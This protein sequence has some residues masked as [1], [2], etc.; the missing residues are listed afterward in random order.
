MTR[1]QCLMTTLSSPSASSILTQSFLSKSSSFLPW[2]LSL[3]AW[4]APGMTASPAHPLSWIWQPPVM[5]TLNHSL[6]NVQA[7]T[8]T[9]AASGLMSALMWPAPPPHST[10]ALPVLRPSMRWFASPLPSAL[11][12]HAV[13]TPRAALLHWRI[14]KI[15]CHRKHL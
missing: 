6:T 8:M 15:V 12:P 14:S 5:T 7:L 1:T 4:P 9:R 13:T 2:T 10:W 11:C 3:R